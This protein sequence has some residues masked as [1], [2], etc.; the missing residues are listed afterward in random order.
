MRLEKKKPTD[1]EN[2]KTLLLAFF[3]K[4]KKRKKIIGRTLR[5][6][7]LDVP[8]AYFSN[9]E[10]TIADKKNYTF[11]E[12]CKAFKNFDRSIVTRTRKKSN[13]EKRIENERFRISCLKNRRNT[14]YLF[15]LCWILCLKKKLSD[16]Y[17]SSDDVN[18]ANINY[19]YVIRYSYSG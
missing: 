17:S 7:C 15:V 19:T 18:D 5:D 1:S 2:R 11:Y 14:A 10:T 9:T 6:L 12:R 4:K 13:Q 16:A 3:C 8:R